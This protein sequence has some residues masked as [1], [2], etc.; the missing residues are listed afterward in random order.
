MDDM[1]KWDHKDEWHRRG[2]DYLVVVKRYSVEPSSFDPH[3]GPH[4]WVVCA[5]IYPK[6]R[7]FSS[8]DGPAMWQPAA[9]ALP[10]HGGPTFLRWHSD[11]DGKP[12]SVQV[13]ADYHHLHDTHFSSYATPSDAWEVFSDAGRL[14]DHLAAIV[15]TPA[16]CDT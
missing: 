10:L 9:A 16:V 3:E 4:R 1:S 6:H 8:F 12:T 5:Y 7:L 11:D 15:E 13:G 2:N 14:F